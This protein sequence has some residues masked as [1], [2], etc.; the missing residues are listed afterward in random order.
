MEALPE[1]MVHEAF[2]V[3]DVDGDGQISLSE[4]RVMLSGRVSADRRPNDRLDNCG[5]MAIYAQYA[6]C[7]ISHGFMKGDIA[8]YQSLFW[9]KRR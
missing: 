7:V 2:D 8:G 1:N 3:F 6:Q 4:L 9:L 5:P